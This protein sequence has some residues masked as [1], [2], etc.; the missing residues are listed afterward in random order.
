MKPTPR[1][2]DFL[3][4][5]RIPS[6]VEQSIPDRFATQ[7]RR[8]A[9]HTAIISETVRLTYAELDRASNGVAQRI[10]QT[11]F[12]PGQRVILLG[13]HDAALNVG[14]F[15]ILKTGNIVVVLNPTEPVLRLKKIAAHADPRLIIADAEHLSLA[16]EIAGKNQVVLSLQDYFSADP[17]RQETLSISPGDIAFL[18]YTSGSSGEPKAVMRSH[19]S[20]LHNAYR[21]AC[22]LRIQPRDR[23]LHLAALSGGSGV[24]GACTALLSGATLCP[25]PMMERAVNGLASWID[26]QGVTV[27]G[28]S[29]SL[30]RSFMRAVPECRQFPTVRSVR[31]TAEPVTADDLT[32]L[33]RHF[34]NDC[35]VV[36]SLSS[37]ETGTITRVRFKTSECDLVGRLPVGY[38]TEDVEMFVLNEKNEQ[39][40]IGEAGEIVVRSRY[41]ADGYWQN[42]QLTKERFSVSDGVIT[43][44]SGD[45][46]RIN[47]HGLLE[48]AGR[49]D[50]RIRIR[51]YRIE[52][53][54]IEEAIRQLEGIQETIVGL[55]PDNPNQLI[56]WYSCQSDH[57]WSPN[58]LR[59]TLSQFLPSYLMPNEFVQMQDF[60]IAANGKIDKAQLRSRRLFDSERNV[61]SSARNETEQQLIEIWEQAFQSGPIGRNDHFF[62]LGGDSLTAVVILAHVSNTWSIDLTMQTLRQ[63]PVLSKL[64]Q[65][66]DRQAGRPIIQSTCQSKKHSRNRVFPLSFAQE[67]IWKECLHNK[68]SGWTSTRRFR[69]E[70][71]LNDEYFTACLRELQRRHEILRSTYQMIDG[72]PSA[73]V[74]ETEELHFDFL[75]F[76]SCAEPEQ[77]A[78]RFYRQVVQKVQLDF[79]RLP[80]MRFWLIRVGHNSY[81]LQR[82]NHHIL[83]DGWSWKIYF[84][85]FKQFYEALLQETKITLPDAPQYGDYAT[86]SRSLQELS[87]PRTRENLDYWRRQLS[88]EP[89]ELILP[90]ERPALCEE[91]HP[92]DGVI[93]WTI[94]SEVSHRLHEIT[95]ESRS[96]FFSIRLAV[97]AATLAEATGQDDLLIGSYS[98]GRRELTHQNTFGMFANTVLLRLHW[99]PHWTFDQW[100]RSVTETVIAMQENDHIPYHTLCRLL[101]EQGLRVPP[102]NTLFCLASHSESRQ[103]G[104][105]TLTKEESESVTIPWGF[106]MLVDRQREDLCHTTFDARRYEPARVSIFIRRYTELLEIFSESPAERMSESMRRP[107]SVSTAANL[108]DSRRPRHDAA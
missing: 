62:D 11:S 50:D 68:M 8:H 63:L 93:P 45:L 94:A 18:V 61:T 31:L 104:E 69:L 36:H 6:D 82:I 5:W 47:S 96:T 108:H 60:P 72:Q 51:G 77:E 39:A 26:T 106:T 7:V 40:G 9:N 30:F 52:P 24:S 103:I 59:R 99:N 2:S 46:G 49:Q 16:Q 84:D 28:I 20:V 4:C 91:A 58:V 66:I 85:E 67:E 21:H 95:S 37:S 73:V 1:D 83:S 56:A 32:A 3:P 90:F 12:F 53:S 81:Q 98:T 41:L 78:E 22:G 54:E 105:F 74:H 27:L 42:E 10:L 92:S 76:A 79:S 43:F 15:G 38:S 14:V 29:T 80:L 71:P 25:F 97:F 101:H 35:E 64:A 33:C 48:Y 44:R 34:S 57:Q 65:L 89:T 23:M 17:I 100:V 55:H 87:S 102:I 75:D 70:G 88:L 13:R 107:T 86:E 19:R